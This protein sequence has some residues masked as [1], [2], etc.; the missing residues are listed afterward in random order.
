MCKCVFVPFVC[1]CYVCL[2]LLGVVLFAVVVVVV[3]IRCVCVFVCAGCVCL[4]LLRVVVLLCLINF[5]MC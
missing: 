4:R 1:S 3:V 5:V 2:R